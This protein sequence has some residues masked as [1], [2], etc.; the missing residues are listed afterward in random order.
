V[1]VA[2]DPVRERQI[3]GVEDTGLC[4]EEANE[5]SGLFDNQTEYER[6]RSDP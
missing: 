1:I 2:L 4:S 6:S 3:G 5:A